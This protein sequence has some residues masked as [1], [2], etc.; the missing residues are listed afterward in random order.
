[1]CLDTSKQLTEA[2]NLFGYMRKTLVTM[3]GALCRAR[4]VGI[5]SRFVEN[6]NLEIH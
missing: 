6:M 1:L 2:Q 4:F 5:L 3:A